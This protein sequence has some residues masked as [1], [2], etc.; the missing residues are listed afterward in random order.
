MIVVNMI[1]RKV[2]FVMMVVI[3]FGLVYLVSRW[4]WLLK[5]VVYM[6]LCRII[7]VNMV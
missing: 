7:C 2:K 1:L 5:K 6:V 4:F 3:L